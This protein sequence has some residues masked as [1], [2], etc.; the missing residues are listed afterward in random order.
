[1]DPGVCFAS[2]LVIHVARDEV[3]VTS[4]PPSVDLPL[5]EAFGSRLVSEPVL[6][7]VGL[8]SGNLPFGK[9]LGVLKGLL[10]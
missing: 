3:S 7:S 5:P 2:D 8:W 10:S 6:S 1:M 9:A 4:T